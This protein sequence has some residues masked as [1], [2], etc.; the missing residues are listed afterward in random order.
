MNAQ[1][2]ANLKAFEKF[3]AM[4]KNG[5]KVRCSKEPL[6]ED[7]R[8]TYFVYAK[9]KRRYGWRYSESD[10]LSKYEPLI[11]TDEEKTA[12]WHKNI[13][14]ALREIE[15]SGFW[16]GSCLE[17]LL[18]NLLKITLNDRHEIFCSGS[19]LEKK[20]DES[21]MKPYMEKYPFLFVTDSEG[22]ITSHPK[23]EYYS[24]LSDCKLK[25]MYFG[26]GNIAKERIKEAMNNRTNI[27][28]RAYTGYDVSFELRQPDEK[29]SYIRAWYS[30]EYRG[31]GNGHYYLA[32]SENC[33]IFGEDD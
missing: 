18:R 31:C 10:F 21:R 8:Q 12:K 30:E 3:E 28:E 14:R 2:F 6:S 23:Y 20:Y 26:R 19:P 32:L 7:G 25:S 15:K 13:Q 29:N 11:P 22:N 24:E 9:G 1:G 5:E 33:A 16:K 17:E 4:S 27:S